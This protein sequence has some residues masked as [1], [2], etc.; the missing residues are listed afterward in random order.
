[1]SFV[2]TSSNLQQEG[3]RDAKNDFPRAGMSVGPQQASVSSPG[4][5]QTSSIGVA[6]IC[7]HFSRLRSRSPQGC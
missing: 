5:P 6:S 7:L 1:M 3:S 4:H 2:G